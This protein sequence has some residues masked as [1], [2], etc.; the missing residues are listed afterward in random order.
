MLPR[1][2]SSGIDREERGSLETS[3][4]LAATVLAESSEQGPPGV[5][6][7]SNDGPPPL[8]DSSSDDGPPPLVD[9]SSDDSPPPLVRVQMTESSS[10]E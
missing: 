10:D 3:P 5:T 4:A 6:E 9:S 1:T 2:L 7:G 8:V